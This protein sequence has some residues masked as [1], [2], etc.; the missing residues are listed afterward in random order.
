MA[1]VF[2]YVYVIGAM[3]VSIPLVVLYLVLNNVRNFT[4][5]YHDGAQMRI[6]KV[7][8]KNV[9][10]G[11][12]F[13][14]KNAIRL[15]KRV[16]PVPVVGQ[17]G[18]KALAYFV[19]KDHCVNMDLEGIDLRKLNVMSPVELE[20]MLDGSDIRAALVAIRQMDSKIWSDPRFLAG[21]GIGLAVGVVVGFAIMSQQPQTV[22]ATLLVNST[23]DG[24]V[25]LI[26]QG[27]TAAF[28]MFGA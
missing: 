27:G 8:K 21:L 16:K 20:S 24:A 25:Q 22:N 3:I 7:A 19:Y 6:V 11:F 15:D 23:K 18:T 28:L 17:F 1:D 10:E 26:K 13:I 5:F 2:M 9:R 12:M 4:V 14:G